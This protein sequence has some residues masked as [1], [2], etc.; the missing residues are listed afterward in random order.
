M[1][2]YELGKT[3][4]RLEKLGPLAHTAAICV[5]IDGAPGLARHDRAKTIAPVWLAR[6]D[7]PGQR[8]AE[9]K[10]QYLL[11]EAGEYVPDAEYL[12][13]NRVALLA[14]IQRS[15]KYFMGPIR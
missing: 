1:E 3:V 4:R 8:S 15:G 13:K 11:E 2:K 6:L 10:L 7:D 5:T 14:A 12:R 9:D